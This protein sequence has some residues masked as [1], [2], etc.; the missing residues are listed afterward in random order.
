M[1]AGKKKEEKKVRQSGIE[2]LR[3]VAMLM[4]ILHHLM[5]YSGA[6]MTT[7][8]STTSRD[9]FFSGISGFGRVGVGI[10]FMITGYFLCAS[11]KEPNPKRIAPIVKVSLFYLIASIVLAFIIIPDK[12]AITFPLAGLPLDF[13]QLYNNGFWWFIGAYILLMVFSP[14]IKKM[15]DAL[16]DKELTRLCIV[17]AV[18]A[19][20]GTDCLRLLCVSD[21][22]PNFVFPTAITYALIGYTIKRR[23]KSIKNCRLVIVALVTGVV[24]IMASPIVY[25]FF[26]NN[27]LGGL[28]DIF[29]REQASGVMLTSIGCFILFLRMKWKNRVVN[30]IASFVLA[31]Y[32]IHNNPFVLNITMWSSDNSIRS[33]LQH[34]LHDKSFLHA[35]AVVAFYTVAIFV[36]CCLIELVRRSVLRLA[37]RA[38][39]R[40]K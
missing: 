36:I 24:L 7:S 14:Q 39:A 35:I 12:M 34:V 16:S 23:E 38:V 32:L 13:A 22:F 25:T 20:V 18:M 11:K 27:N 29:R 10:F 2:L 33:R 26:Y 40:K 21:G 19:S 5:L 17:I 9:Y 37:I 28:T 1:V 8:P 31:V 15:L 4:I 6:S 30:Y 3:I